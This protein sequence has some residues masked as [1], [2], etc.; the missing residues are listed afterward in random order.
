MTISI[1]ITL[2]TES[3]VFDALVQIA[4]CDAGLVAYRPSSFEASGGGWPFPVQISYDQKKL[5]V[6]SS[7]RLLSL[8]TSSKSIAII[9]VGSTWVLADGTPITTAG[10]VTLR[11]TSIQPVRIILDVTDAG[12]QTYYVR[13]TKMEPIPMTL[14][15]LLYHELA[16]AYHVIRGDHPADEAAGEVLVHA[17]ENAFRSQLGLP[18]RHPTL[19]AGG[20]SLIPL[21][22]DFPRCESSQ[23]SAWGLGK[24]CMVA[25]A[26]A[27][28]SHAPQVAALRRARDEFRSLGRW[29]EA[30]SDPVL[31][32][33]AK[34]SPAVVRDMQADPALRVAVLRYAVEPSFH[35][36][37]MV[38][39]F[40]GVRSDSPELQTRLNACIDQFASKMAGWG[41]NASSL[42]ATAGAATCASQR[43][44]SAPVSPAPASRDWP[45]D[46]YPYLASAIA[47]GG[48]DTSG[49][50]WAFEGLALLFH[51]ASAK[52][53]TAC[54][55]DPDLPSALGAWL[56]RLPIPTDAQLTLPEAREALSVLSERFFGEAR[57]RRLF[58]EHLLVHWPAPTAPALRSLMR[59]LDYIPTD[60]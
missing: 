29:A 52:C 32:A 11:E 28:S 16:H 20:V 44:M 24:V 37:N 5:G 31:A 2:G 55:A 18:L 54:E 36:L 34:F 25:T 45:R 17:D 60:N 12:G 35:L 49:F 33:Y 6:T 43:L 57:T 58:A 1:D 14:P 21:D 56:A 3:T 10:G 42:Q 50:A 23:Q 59:D 19:H 4:R 53:T 27:G 30:I 40:L 15:V 47:S 48:G 46:L 13:D 22:S 8:V 26:A 9:G 38:D 41:Q 51:L 7:N 39:A